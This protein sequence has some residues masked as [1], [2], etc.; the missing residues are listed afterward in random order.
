MSEADEV[1]SVEAARNLDTTARAWTTEHLLDYI[2]DDVIATHEAFIAGAEWAAAE[3]RKEAE[4]LREALRKIER[5]E[6][7]ASGDGPGAT[8]AELTAISIARTALAA[9]SPISGDD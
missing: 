7:T 6:W 5:A 8:W 1:S 9:L 2:R 4:A 3:A